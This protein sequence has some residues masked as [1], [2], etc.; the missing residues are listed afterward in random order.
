MYKS[1]RWSYL[2]S[3]ILAAPALTHAKC[4]EDHIR[5]LHDKGKS[6]SAIADQCD[7]SRHDVS[8]GLSQKSPDD[9]DADG[10]EDAPTVSRGWRPGQ[11]LIACGCWGMVPLGA[12]QPNGQ[13]AS[14]YDQVAACYGACPTGGAPWTRVCR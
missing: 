14:G 4:S 10:D 2:A 13:C 8:V 6:I 3:L 1:L 9:G 7:M 5:Y 12:I 11:Q